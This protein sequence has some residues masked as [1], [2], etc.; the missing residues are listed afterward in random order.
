MA[1]GKISIQSV[2]DISVPLGG[3][4]IRI[5]HTNPRPVTANGTVIFPNNTVTCTLKGPGGTDTRIVVASRNAWYVDFGVKS[6]GT[7]LLNA[8][9]P[10]EGCDGVQVQVP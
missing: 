9:A 8:C 7:Y 2:A 4:P 3:K 10:R 6:P 1:E 5:D